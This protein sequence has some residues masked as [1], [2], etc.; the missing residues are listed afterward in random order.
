M[1]SPAPPATAKAYI[2]CA[3][4]KLEAGLSE[5]GFSIVSNRCNPTRV[6]NVD[7]RT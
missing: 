2:Q 6:D 7:D 4:F 5:S 1:P 3:H